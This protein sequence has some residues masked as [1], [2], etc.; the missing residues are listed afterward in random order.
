MIRHNVCVFARCAI[1][2][3]AAWRPGTTPSLG[4]V[5]RV[6]PVPTK[7]L[8]VS[9]RVNLVL[10]GYSEPASSPLKTST[11]AEVSVR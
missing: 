7:T 5:S 6:P 8:R 2:C 4:R 1:Q 3:R 10:T 9:W 11:N